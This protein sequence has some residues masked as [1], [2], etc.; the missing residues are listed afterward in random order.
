M[1]DLA[2]WVRRL[3]AGE[4]DAWQEF[5]QTFARFVPIVSR[6]YGLSEA[7]RQEVLQD[8]TVTAFR[9]IRN[10]RDPARLSSWTFTIA[11]RAAINLWKTNHRGH[12]APGPE[13][14]IPDHLPSGQIPPDEMMA[15]IEDVHQVRLAL[16]R[17]GD[18]CRQLLQS[19]FLRE[20]RL[21][22]LEISET[23]GIPVGSIGPTLA[24]C[25]NRMRQNLKSVSDR[26]GPLPAGMEESKT[27]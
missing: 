1:R 18:R 14:P 15:R 19:L 24:R 25:L 12:A 3:Q 20:P 9:S 11:H 22:Y 23:H 2:E 16:E 4:D 27:S 7:D 21:S 10:L 8:M 13:D 26:P 5:I 17:L 6:R